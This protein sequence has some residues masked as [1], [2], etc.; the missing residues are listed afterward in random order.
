MCPQKVAKSQNKP[1]TAKTKNTLLKSKIK[2]IQKHHLLRIPI[3]L[4]VMFLVCPKSPFKRGF[5]V[6]A[7][8]SMSLFS[9]F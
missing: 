4:D 1:N 5:L 9:P 2:K 3:I 6:L 8:K 7:A